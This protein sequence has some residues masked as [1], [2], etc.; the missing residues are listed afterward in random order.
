MRV[1]RLMGSRAYAVA[2]GMA[3]LAWIS[4]LTDASA[5]QAI[6]FRKTGAVARVSDASL[7]DLKQKIQQ[8]VIL[9]GQIT[10]ARILR[11]IGPVAV[12]ADPD[13]EECRLIRLNRAVAGRSERGNAFARPDQ[14]E[15]AGHLYFAFV[16]DTEAV[17]RSRVHHPLRALSYPGAHA[18]AYIPRAQRRE[19]LR[20]ARALV[21]PRGLAPTSLSA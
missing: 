2:D 16:A 8:F 19:L 12:D 21:F 10:G 20:R 14:G 7:K 15:S 11:E 18:R 5:N 1:G 9:R 13:F 3:G 4:T 17:H 6:E